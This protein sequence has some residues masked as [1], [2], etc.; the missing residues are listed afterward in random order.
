M[1]RIKMFGALIVFKIVIH[2]LYVLRVFK[3]SPDLRCNNQM[4]W[5]TNN[6]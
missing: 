3:T 5:F 6:E 4:D 2:V 1:Y